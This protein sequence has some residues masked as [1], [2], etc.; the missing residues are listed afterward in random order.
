MPP[1]RSLEDA[2]LSQLIEDEN[3]QN[4]IL[5]TDV[6]VNSLVSI[7]KKLNSTSNAL[8][9]ELFEQVQSH[10]EQFASSYNTSQDIQAQVL[11][12]TSQVSET[13][14]I[15]S[16]TQK[17]ATTT[18]EAYQHALLESQKNQARINALQRIE[19]ILELIEC[20]HDESSRY[21]YL[22]SVNH[23]IQLKHI[24]AKDWKDDDPSNST[25][26]KEI[27]LS[28][29]E[30][31]E[32][33]IVLSLQEGIHTA[34]QCS[35]GSIRVFSFFQP[36]LNTKVQLSDIF[37]S[38]YQLGLLPEEWMNVQRLVF[39][40]I[41]IPYFEKSGS[42]IQIENVQTESAGTGG[43]LQIIRD[44]TDEDEDGYV[45]P[46]SMINDMELILDFLYSNFF[47]NSDNDKDMKLLFGN[48]FL[49]ELINLMISKGIAPA[50]PSTRSNLSDFK[51]VADS[52]IKFENK[53]EDKY[54]FQTKDTI[55]L[56]DYVKNID[57][58]YAKK[59]SERILQEGRKVM[60]RRLY[61]TDKT[62]IKG[63]KEN[64]PIYECQ[65]TQTPEILSVLISDTLSEAFDLLHDSHTISANTLVD[66]LG[67]LLDMYR[68]IMPS[69]HRT[70]YLMSPANSLVFRNDCLWL[71]NQLET[72]LSPNALHSFPQLS[73]LLK[74]SI[75]RLKELGNAWHELTMTQR[76]EMIQACL[77]QLNGFS[78]MMVMENVD[79]FQQVC[80][81]V[82]SQV[83]DLVLLFAKEVRPVIDEVLF[84][85]MLGR[86]TESILNRL[87]KDIEAIKDI[88]AE[89]SHV[90][91]RALNS[92]AQLVGAFDLPTSDAT[93]SFVS[94]LVPSW[95]KFWLLKDILEM[96]MREI[97]ES[98]HRG[99]LHMF[100]KTEL[101]GL[102][103][104]LFADTNLRESNIEEIKGGQSSNRYETPPSYTA[105]IPSQQEQS[106]TSFA[107]PPASTPAV[108]STSGSIHSG[109]QYTLDDDL[110]ETEIGWKDDDDDDLFKDDTYQSLLNS[111]AENNSTGHSR[112]ISLEPSQTMDI[113]DTA[114]GWSDADEDV[115]KDDK[116]I[117]SSQ[118]VDEL[119]TSFKTTHD[120][121]SK[122]TIPTVQKPSISL[123]A[124]DLDMQ[125]LEEGE[126]WGWDDDDDD[127][128][129]EE[130]ED[131]K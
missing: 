5:K 97:M 74:E 21:T 38:L 9:Q 112:C 1:I 58:H 41:F 4:V 118:L 77:D 71:A 86:I 122:N 131:I 72:K 25:Q 53:F 129:N 6:E 47:N 108:S 121:G 102:L 64:E 42:R 24:L 55:L 48:L 91:A 124:P 45:E 82:I 56:T 65:I 90:I 61:D 30:Q 49:P 117:G 127:I 87:I 39:K 63:Q 95:H 96:N 35:L 111:S 94:E 115:F 50:I 104:S 37:Q 113:D 57:K 70:Q 44:T 107:S 130:E 89:E 22:D 76:L 84:L 116:L 13:E 105:K 78:G 2:F 43:V 16:E 18:I 26:I 110:E 125:E 33:S 20:I 123:S 103:C 40:N 23:L 83:I 36:N 52:V 120:E 88:G 12:M 54:G 66:G 67:D 99:D 126:G 73:V 93:E 17:Q 3:I 101:I 27:I 11:K 19:Q 8:Q 59:R 106:S 32:Q 98:F 10:F 114:D 68:A 100:E 75:E 60:L 92:F 69:Y 29:V 31:L 28:R 62:T 15:V 119:P 81:Q 46:I 80:E 7:L 51:R 128:F 34:I 14:T 109:L 79:K 85:D